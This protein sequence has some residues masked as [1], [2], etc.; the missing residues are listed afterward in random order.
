MGRSTFTR[1]A[2]DSASSKHV[3]K[4]GPITRAAQERIKQTGKLDPLVDPAEFGVIRRSLLRFEEQPSGLFELTIGCSMPIETRLDT[5]GSMG[6]YVDRAYKVLPD[7]YD[8]CSQML[9]GYDVHVAIGIF[10]DCIDKFVLCRPQYEMLA[11][12]IVHQLT[13]MNPERGGGGNGGEDP[14]Y[15]IFGS[16]YLTA[17]YINRI[18]LKR[19]DFTISDEPARYDLRENQLIRIFGDAV[20]DKVKANGFS[21]DRNDLPSTKEVVQDLLK[22]AHA[23]FLEVADGYGW[24][25]A[26]EFW[27]EIYGPERVIVLPEIEMLPQVQAIIIGLTEGTLSL[28]QVPNFLAEF[29]VRSVV[30]DHIQESVANIPIGAQAV[31]RDGVQVPQKG[32]LYRDKGDLWP[33]DPSELDL[34]VTDQVTADVG[35]GEDG[36]DWL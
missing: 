15:G 2:Y 32:D 16:A 31:L 3:P 33:I 12:K 5:T 8:L 26:H 18:G 20:F 17:A 1:S 6:D 24:G 21:V 34:D 7:L 19:Y 28:D 25:G 9:P 29:K 36:P 14:H 4:K 30:V 35:S 13:L 27:T 11:E 23:F 22:Q 10:G